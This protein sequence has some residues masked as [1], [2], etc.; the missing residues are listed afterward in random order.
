MARLITSIYLIGVFVIAL[1]ASAA[2]ITVTEAGDATTIADDGACSLREAVIAANANAAVDGCSAGQP[3]PAIDQIRFDPTLDGTPIV[4]AITGRGEESAATGDLDITES[5]DIV[6]NGKLVPDIGTPENTTANTL[7][8][9]G[10]I[11]G[12]DRVFDIHGGAAVRMEQLAVSGGFASDPA[13]GGGIFVRADGSLTLH[14]VLVFSNRTVSLDLGGTAVHAG[15]GVAARGRLTLEHTAVYANTAAASGDDIA[16]GGG[17]SAIGNLNPLTIEDSVIVGNRASASASARGGGIAQ[18]A[19]SSFSVRDSIIRKNA[20]DSASE[21]LG[22]GIYTSGGS[23]NFFHVIERSEIS[24]NSASAEGMGAGRGGGVYVRSGADRISNSTVSANGVKVTD[25]GGGF[26][27]PAQGGGLWVDSG[28]VTFNNVTITNNVATDFASANATGG[29]L[30]A[31]GAGAEVSVSNTVIAGNLARGAGDDCTGAPI[32]SG[33]YTLLGNNDACVFMAG[34]GDLIGTRDSPIDP[35]LE[36][37]GAEPS[38][39]GRAIQIG[40]VSLQMRFHRPA[41]GPMNPL[42]PVVDAGN[43]NMVAD[44]SPPLCEAVDQ[45]G[46][47]RPAD[48]S[49]GGGE[50]CDIGAVELNAQPAAAPGGATDGGT[51]G[52]GCALTSDGA[53][54]PLFYFMA[55]LALLGLRRRR[56]NLRHDEALA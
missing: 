12:I 20:A 29:G 27:G 11:G 51:G 18:S 46:L 17:I 9:G 35:E 48:G 40:E 8:D 47:V 16:V 55:L 6:G 19:G 30:V 7:I 34:P 26:A 15:G 1:P 43:P 5:V 31:A 13:A 50:R 10:R 54:D 23:A 36:P 38:S 49:S 42:S 25:D 52:G 21:A 32:G 33:G 53:P 2:T 41:G 14:H 3:L 22:G 37:L 4:L 45:R 28:I 24:S 39:F 56:R 44:A